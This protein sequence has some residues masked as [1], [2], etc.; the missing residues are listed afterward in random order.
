MGQERS[1]EQ[2]GN[3]AANPRLLPASGALGGGLRE[4]VEKAAIFADLSTADADI[5]RQYVQ[6]YLAEPGLTLFEEG[7][8]GSCLYVVVDGRIDLFKAV[9]GSPRKIHSVRSGRTLGEMSLVDGLPYSATAVAAEPTRL[10]IMT[11]S[12]FA[13]MVTEQPAV[14]LKLALGLGR[15][16]SLRLRQTTGVLLDH[17]EHNTEHG[18]EQNK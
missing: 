2:Q 18:N 15:M 1:G 16:M 12:L 11:R 5:L 8:A 9:S 3:S 4:M 14:A 7:D 6:A 13:R 17:L 10:L